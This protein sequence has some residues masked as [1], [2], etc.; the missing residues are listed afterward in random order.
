MIKHLLALF[1]KPA[2]PPAPAVH[3]PAA[4][5]PDFRGV[6]I[7]SSA[8]CCAAARDSAG[9]RW[10]MRNAPRLPLPEC[11]IPEGCQCKFKKVSDRRGSDRRLLGG[12]A[13]NRWYGGTE[14]RQHRGRR[15]LDLRVS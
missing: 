8:T 6:I 10:L 7:S 14:H 12:T 13:M 3:R 4:S 5:G 9:T 1:A 15:S 11:S 2:P